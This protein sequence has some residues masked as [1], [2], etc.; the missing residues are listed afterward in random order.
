MFGEKNYFRK[1]KGW[2]ILKFPPHIKN[3]VMKFVVDNGKGYFS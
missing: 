3:A 2:Y 1:C